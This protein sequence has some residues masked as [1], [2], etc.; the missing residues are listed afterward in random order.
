MGICFILMILLVSP[1]VHPQSGSVHIQGHCPLPHSLSEEPGPPLSDISQPCWFQWVYHSFMPKASTWAICLCLQ[2]CPLHP[3]SLRWHQG[4]TEIWIQCCLTQC[5][6]VCAQRRVKR[7][8]G[9]KVTLPVP[10]SITA[11]VMSCFQWFHR[12][13]T[14]QSL[15]PHSYS[16]AVLAVWR[17]E[18]PRSW[19]VCRSRSPRG[20][21]KLSLIMFIVRLCFHHNETNRA[22]DRNVAG[23]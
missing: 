11:W 8:R 9:T 14:P 1:A 2:V 18:Q 21:H 13:T 6:V 19:P 16:G 10:L 22:I 12:S 20:Q 3:Q 4:S 15:I 5:R 17:Q 7:I 23:L